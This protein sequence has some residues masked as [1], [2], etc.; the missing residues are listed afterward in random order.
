M[1][2]KDDMKYI[3][4]TRE[5]LEKLIPDGSYSIGDDNMMCLTGKGGYINY[6]LS[7]TEKFNEMRVTAAE[8]GAAALRISRKVQIS[9]YKRLVEMIQ[10]S[11]PE[12]LELAEEIIRI[13]KSTDG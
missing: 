6:I 11:D 10:S 12:N 1:A 5:E 2:L 3:S 4:K 13:K 7:L 8:Y 9:E